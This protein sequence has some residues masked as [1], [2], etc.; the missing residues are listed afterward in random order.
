M[1]TAIY[2]RNSGEHNSVHYGIAAALAALA[3]LALAVLAGCGKPPTPAAA[4]G[5]RAADTNVIT[6]EVPE[7]ARRSA[8]E[9]ESAPRGADMAAVESNTAAYALSADAAARLERALSFRSTNDFTFETISNLVADIPSNVL[10]DRIVPLHR[11]SRPSDP[12]TMAIMHMFEVI[13]LRGTPPAAAL[14]A[15]H[16]VGNFYCYNGSCFPDRGDAWGMAVLDGATLSPDAGE[17][18]RNT[19]V[20]ILYEAMRRSSYG[21]PRKERSEDCL[22]RI[23]H[24]EQ[25]VRDGVVPMGR[26]PYQML[27]I[28]K[29]RSLIKLKRDEEAIN[30]L[31]ELYRRRED[32]D[33]SL[34]MMLKD[35]PE[36]LFTDMRYG[37]TDPK[38]IEQ[39][40]AAEARQHN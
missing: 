29:A 13:M 20:S 3:A 6:V 12:L 35:G 31:R 4:D 2:S 25:L 37:T 21:A 27:S 36:M 10:L 19:Y 17:A 16:R 40:K 32:L 39:V 5:A 33:P 9:A 8:G 7:P 15:R 24:L 18:E 22:R 38:L 23:A 1:R 34:Q 26:Q 30:I 28:F 14:F 11:N